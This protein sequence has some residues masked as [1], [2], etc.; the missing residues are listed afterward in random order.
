MTKAVSDKH[1]YTINFIDTDPAILPSK[2]DIAMDKVVE[3][4]LQA[5]SEEMLPRNGMT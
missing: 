3:D 5:L 1:A 2:H 4:L